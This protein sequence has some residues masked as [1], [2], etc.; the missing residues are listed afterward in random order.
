MKAYN[1]K[2]NRCELDKFSHSQMP[3]WHESRGLCKY[4]ELWS[5]TGLE[6]NSGFASDSVESQIICINSTM[7]GYFIC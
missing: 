1:F 5:H 7:E 6:S 4:H 2:E 3:L